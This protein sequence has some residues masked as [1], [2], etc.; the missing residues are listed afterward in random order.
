MF[1]NDTLQPFI[2]EENLLP[3]LATFFQRLWESDEVVAVLIAALL[4][5]IGWLLIRFFTPR[6]KLAWGVSH[7]H[8]FLLQNPQPGTLV[9]TKQLWIQNVG[10]APVQGIEVILASSPNH[11]DIWP[12]RHFTTA[13]N[14]SGNLV[15][16]VDN[17][18][19][20]EHFTVSMLNVGVDTPPVT[21]V[22]WNGGVGRERL[23]APGQVF[24]SWQRR[25]A[26]SLTLMGTFSVLYFFSRAI[27][28]IWF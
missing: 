24:K 4:S 1:A 27:V 8:A 12:Q 25:L 16:N 21:N 26:E 11:F 2:A 7:Q 10:R 23:M 13:Q 19:R 5:V 28:H 18:S 14:P 22:R 9:Y 17:L 20:R 3:P 6:G 15:I